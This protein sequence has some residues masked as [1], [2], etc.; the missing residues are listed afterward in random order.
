M[1]SAGIRII[2]PAPIIAAPRPTWP[3]FSESSVRTS[4]NSLPMSL[5]NCAIASLKSSGIDRLFSDFIAI[6]LRIEA[7]LI[8]G[9][10]R[11]FISTRLC[12]LPLVGLGRTLHEPYRT[13][14]GEHGHAQKCG[15]L[16]ARKRLGL[17]HEIVEV[18]APDLVRDPFNLG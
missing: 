18:T 4:S 16:A 3:T 13:E 12:L 14:A 11:K 10:C 5:A 6:T 17:A 1:I 7:R 8:H 2:A 15:G 9:A